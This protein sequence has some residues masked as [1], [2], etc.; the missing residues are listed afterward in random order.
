M[1]EPVVVP[2][3]KTD[4]VLFERPEVSLLAVA[5]VPKSTESPEVAIVI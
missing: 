3:P 4:L 1:V 2:P 5:N